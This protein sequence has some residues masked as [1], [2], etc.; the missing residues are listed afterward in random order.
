MLKTIKKNLIFEIQIDG[1]QL[2][3]DEKFMGV[4]REFENFQVMETKRAQI[5]ITPFKLKYLYT[6]RTLHLRFLF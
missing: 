2:I 3:I 1:L 5:N 4:I 6:L